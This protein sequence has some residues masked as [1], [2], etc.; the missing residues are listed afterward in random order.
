M[1]YFYCLLITWFSM[2][3]IIYIASKI[4]VDMESFEELDGSFQMHFYIFL[5]SLIWPLSTIA[6][7]YGV[8][9]NKK[10]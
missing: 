10:Y 3:T 6:I 1:W 8:F 4:G 2:E 5:A 7:I 9:I